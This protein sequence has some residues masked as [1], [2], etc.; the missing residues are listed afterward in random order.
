MWCIIVQRDVSEWAEKIWKNGYRSCFVY[1]CIYV[2]NHATCL[3]NLE[4]GEKL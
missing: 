1:V 2:A 4:N 3:A